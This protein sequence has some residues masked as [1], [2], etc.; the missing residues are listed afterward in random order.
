[1]PALLDQRERTEDIV[2]TRPP[3]RCPNFNH[4][5]PDAPV[6]ACPMC[7]A[8]VNPKIRERRCSDTEHAVRRREG[9]AYCVDCGEHLRRV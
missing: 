7:G 9:A 3:E 4:G 2:T 5:R 6:R 8:V 1:M